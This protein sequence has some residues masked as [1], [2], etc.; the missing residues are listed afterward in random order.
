MKEKKEG[1]S[2]MDVL[3]KEY[4]ENWTLLRYHY[5]HIDKWIKYYWTVITAIT[6]AIYYVFLK[7]FG[8]LK[9]DIQ[10]IGVFLLIFTTLIGFAT[11]TV[12]ATSRKSVIIISYDLQFIKN[13]I[14]RIDSYTS[15]EKQESLSDEG[16]SFFKYSK[17]FDG[18]TILII[19]SN[20]ILVSLISA[21]MVTD[22]RI[23]QIYK[24][25]FGIIFGIIIFIGQWK[26]Y[27]SILLE[28]IGTSRK[29]VA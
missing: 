23:S 17:I 11:L 29:R 5:E 4:E 10:V 25:M 3:L 13:T 15:S 16:L 9:V 18:P 2:T 26:L 24:L 1:K 27:K 14:R 21:F 6:L 19:L 8:A 12:I 20:C 22:E 28:K 7:D